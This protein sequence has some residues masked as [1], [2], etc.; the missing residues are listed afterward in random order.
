MWLKATLH[1]PLFLLNRQL[2]P[3]SGGFGSTSQIKSKK[4]LIGHL[5]ISKPCLW[6]WD[7]GPKIRGNG[8]SRNTCA[9]PT[10]STSATVSNARPS[11]DS[12]GPTLAEQLQDPL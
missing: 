3:S 6:K 5:R 8:P 12:L 1:F 10:T 4:N 2:P 7:K 9:C 11:R